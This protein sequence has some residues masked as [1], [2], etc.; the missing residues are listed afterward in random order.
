MDR[1]RSVVIDYADTM[2]AAGALDALAEMGRHGV[3]SPLQAGT[4][5]LNAR[6]YTAA[7]G[8]FDQVGSENPEWGAARFAYATTLM[9]M[10]REDEARPTLSAARRQWRRGGSRAAA[11]G[12]A[13]GAGRRVRASRGDLPAHDVPGPGTSAGGVVSG[14]VRA[15][16]AQ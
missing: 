2:R 14:R 10:G 9:R 7:L 4:A 12:S 13:A 15:L 8:L 11:A 3:V 5:R 16:H 6:E 1:F